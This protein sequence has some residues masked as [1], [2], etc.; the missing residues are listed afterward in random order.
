MDLNKITDYCNYIISHEDVDLVFANTINNSVSAY[1][2]QDKFKLIP[3]DL[4]IL[5]YPAGGLCGSLWKSGK[6]AEL[7]HNYFITNS[8][9]FLNYSYNN[10]IIPILTR[11]SINFFGY[12]GKNWHKIKNCYVDDEKMLTVDYVKRYNFKNVLYSSFYVSHLSFFKQVETF[13]NTD[14]LLQKY[15]SFFYKNN[16][17]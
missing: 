8:D 5:E 1:Y 14:D 3:K 11:F 10:E 17:T 6:K 9:S 16:F 12:L 2:Q 4:M 7:L 13:I 15:T